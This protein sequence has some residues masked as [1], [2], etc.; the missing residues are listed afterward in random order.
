[1]L[2]YLNQH[3]YTAVITQLLDMFSD[4]PL[5]H[6]TSGQKENLQAT[7]TFY[8]VSAVRK[9]DY[10]RHDLAAA[11][12][13]RN[14][15]SNDGIKIYSGGIR[16]TLYNNDCLL[17]KHS[18]FRPGSGLEAFSHLH[19]VDKARV[20]DLSCVMLHYKFTS[21]AR[22]AAARNKEGFKLRGY[23]DFL[24]L[25]Q[26]KPDQRIKQNGAREFRSVRELV[27]KRFFGGF[28]GIPWVCAGHATK[29]GR[30]RARGNPRADPGRPLPGRE[31]K[32]AR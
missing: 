2:E 3:Q 9:T 6:L 11:F 22:Q 26:N 12:G 31:I 28:P 7:Y 13:G 8:D 1:M 30:A 23:Q 24:E 21:S 19:F 29:R 25:L 14:E 32:Q 18:L 17:T 10:R 15:L 20:A 5:S 16:K 27:E 4:K